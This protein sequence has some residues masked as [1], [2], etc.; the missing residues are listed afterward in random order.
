MEMIGLAKGG[1]DMEQGARHCIGI[2]E[3]KGNKGE[4]GT[5]LATKFLV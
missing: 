1:W 2:K 5:E 4:K 3:N